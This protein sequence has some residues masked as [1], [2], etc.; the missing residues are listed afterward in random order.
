[1]LPGDIFKLL[2]NSTKL[3][4]KSLSKQKHAL[5]RL[6]FKNP[7]RN[8]IPTNYYCI[9]IWFS[10]TPKIININIYMGKCALPSSSTNRKLN[11]PNSQMFLPH[12]LLPY[13]F[14]F[15][16]DKFDVTAWCGI[17]WHESKAYPFKSTQKHTPKS[18]KRQIKI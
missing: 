9:Y 10:A 3:V 2:V 17:S 15:F 8:N 1:M 16:D 13:E 12:H 14:Y 5:F 4:K 6:H 7:N 18:E 11:L